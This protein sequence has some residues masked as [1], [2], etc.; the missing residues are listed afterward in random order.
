MNK[1]SNYWYVLVLTDYGVKF[2]TSIKNGCRTAYWDS[3]GKPMEFSM[4]VAK[5]IAFGLNC[6]FITAYPVCTPVELRSQPYMYDKG[7]FE[8]R[9]DDDDGQERPES[10]DKQSE[11]E[12]GQNGGDE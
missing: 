6:N 1:K 11:D 4:S 12:S 3:V 5:D 7:H 2:V 9:W 8:W 10:S